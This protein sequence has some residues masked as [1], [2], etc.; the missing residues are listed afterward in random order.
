MADE[1]RSVID[2]WDLSEVLAAF[3]QIARNAGE[4]GGPA[5]TEAEAEHWTDRVLPSDAQP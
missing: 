1:K 2:T 4:T 3:R 5:V